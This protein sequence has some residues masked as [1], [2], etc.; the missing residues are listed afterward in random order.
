MANR[1]N[2]SLNKVQPKNKKSDA[3]W[4]YQV[5]HRT[6]HNGDDWFAIHEAHLNDNGKIFAITENPMAVQAGTL[7]GLRQQLKHML[8]DAEEHGVFDLDEPA[9][10]QNPGKSIPMDQPRK[11]LGS[12]RKKSKPARR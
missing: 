11:A 7:G 3:G 9:A 5:V 10:P 4:H 6:L 1:A 12:A 2:K 8:E